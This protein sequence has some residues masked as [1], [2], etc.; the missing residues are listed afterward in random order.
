MFLNLYNGVSMWDPN[1]TVHAKCLVHCPSCNQYSIIGN[2]RY[3]A[4]LLFV[5]LPLSPV[6]EPLKNK[7]LSYSF[8]SLELIK[9]PP[10][11]RC[12][13]GVCGV[14]TLYAFYPVVS[15][16]LPLFH[17]SILELKGCPSTPPPSTPPPPGQA[18]FPS[19][20]LAVFFCLALA[21]K[22]PAPKLSHCLWF[23]TP[24][25]PCPTQLYVATQVAVQWC[26][27]ASLSF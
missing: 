3:V 2:K 5:Q 11:S 1:N 24:G 20:G 13:I 25:A 6:H 16:G 18:L 26:V 12:L 14:M 19:R 10:P 8:L 27:Q 7:I 21:Y 23:I 9:V 22:A 17:C 15:L 4:F